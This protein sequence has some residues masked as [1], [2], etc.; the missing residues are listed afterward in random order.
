[1]ITL[2]DISINVKK[3]SSELLVIG[4]FNDSDISK[5]A[6]YLI[7]EDLAKISEAIKVDLTKGKKNKNIFVYGTGSFKRILF[8]CLGDKDKITNDKLRGHGS[9]LFNLVNDAQI[10]SMVIDTICA[11]LTKLNNLEP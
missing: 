8:Y 7:K 3:H 5:S 1:M 2:K 11:S 9:K 10:V 6:S 4:Y